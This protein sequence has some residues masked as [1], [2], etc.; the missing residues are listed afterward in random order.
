MKDD[1]E[2]ALKPQLPPTVP[3]DLQRLDSWFGPAR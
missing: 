3:G 2:V 1:G